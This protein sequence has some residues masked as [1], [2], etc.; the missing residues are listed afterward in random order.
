MRFRVVFL[1]FCLIAVLTA[2]SAQN[3]S[4]DFGFERAASVRVRENCRDLCFPWAGGVN[5]VRFSEID[6]DLDGIP[7][8]LGFEKHGNRLLPFLRRGDGYEYAPQYARRFP[9]LHDWVILHDYN[10]DG[11][12]DIFTYGLASIRVFENV[13]GDSLAFQ[14]AADPLQAF[15]YNGYT[16]IY[17]SPDDYLVVD[18]VDGDGH[19]DILNFW[20]LGKFVHQLRNYAA[21]GA[22]FNFRLENECWGHFEEA[23]DNNAVTLFSDCDS[24][25][26]DDHT[27]HTGSSM[28]LHDFDGNGLPD[29]LLGDIDSPYNILLY[30]HGTLSDARMTIQDTAYP[31]YLPVMLYSMPAASFVTLPGHEA[32]SMLVSPSDPSLTKSQDLNSV[33]VYDYDS[34]ITQYTLSQTDYLQGEMMDVGSG[35][36]PV[37][38]DFDGDGLVDMF[39]GNYGQFDSAEV[40]NGWLTSYFSSSVSYYRNTGTVSKPEFTLQNRDFG[41]LKDLSLNAMHPAFGDFD[42]DGQVDMLCGLQDGTLIMVPHQRLMTGTGDFTMHYAQVDAGECSTPQYFDL[43]RDGRK[44]LIIGNR[45]GL[46]SYYRNIGTNIPQ[47][48][49]ITDTLGGVDMRDFAQSYF[50]YSVPCF[51]RDV[52]HGTV[53]FCAGEEGEVAYYKHIDGNLDGVFEKVEDNLAETVSGVACGFREG[54]RVAAAVADLTGDGLPEMVLGNYAGGAA[55]FSGATPPAHTS[56]SDRVLPQLRVWPNPTSGIIHVECDRPMQRIDVYDLY[57]R[58]MLTLRDMPENIARIDLSSFPAGVFFLKAV[59]KGRTVAVRKVVKH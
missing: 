56:L 36:H 33:W 27:R 38:Y 1:T 31:Q 22:P 18:D 42:G 45:R 3:D 35:C 28:L 13:S 52:Q 51:Y 5:S 15:Y 6:L 25:S 49:K 50:G 46:L 17:A 54:R 10:H 47:F 32:P 12:A 55:Y 23:A 9:D 7:D 37:L 43:D 53:L 40:T 20:V 24:K 30:N 4:Y 16:N 58:V 14:L 11:K 34:L 59:A 57:G 29:L 26:D 19:L 2:G 41:N 44:D 48:Q 39:L 21:D 8:L